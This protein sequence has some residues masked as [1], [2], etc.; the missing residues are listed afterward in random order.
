MNAEQIRA[1]ALEKS[2]EVDALRPRIDPQ[3]RDIEL[4]TR[5]LAAL[6][7]KASP[8][9]YIEIEGA[10]DFGFAASYREGVLDHI[11][12]KVLRLIDEEITIPVMRV[13]PFFFHPPVEQP[14]VEHC[15]A[16]PE[17]APSEFGVEQR[18]KDWT[19]FKG[20]A[21]LPEGCVVVP[22]EPTEAMKKAAE[23]YRDKCLVTPGMQ[24]TFGGYYRA[25]IAA[26]EVKP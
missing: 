5:F 11:K 26:G 21:P 15:A 12:D 24:K 4:C 3:D 23:A 14:A 22:M 8:D 25:M 1:I 2:R 17:P 6:T 13:V 9:G 20:A 16:H 18:D 19:A 7:D 10:K